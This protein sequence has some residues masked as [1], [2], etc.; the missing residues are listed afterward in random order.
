MRR[1]FATLLMSSLLITGAPFVRDDGPRRDWNPIHIIKKI[2][3]HLLPSPAD[4]G[5]TAGTPKP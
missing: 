3:R 1:L 2:V 5:D 4:D